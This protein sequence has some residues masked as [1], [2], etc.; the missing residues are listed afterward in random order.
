MEPYAGGPC[1]WITWEYCPP[2]PV[3]PCF[4]A[5]HNQS[6]VYDPWGRHT[7]VPV[8]DVDIAVVAVALLRLGVLVLQPLYPGLRQSRSHTNNPVVQ[9]RGYGPCA[10]ISPAQRRRGGRALT[11]CSREHC[12]IP[13]I[14]A[15][16]SSVK[17]IREGNV[18]EEVTRA[19]GENRR[20]RG[21]KEDCHCAACQ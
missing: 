8:P 19:A 7:V 12:A 11:G 5:A 15:K 17:H 1:C 10:P 16:D 21:R 3:P 6:R 13:L 2:A 9:T 18:D 4:D 20:R 14:S